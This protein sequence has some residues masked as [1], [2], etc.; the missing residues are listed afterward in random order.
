MN[1]KV[2]S[3]DELYHTTWEN[4]EGTQDVASPVGGVLE[5]VG[6]AHPYF[7]IDETD[8]LASVIARREDVEAV[9]GGWVGEEE[10]RRILEEDGAGVE[11]G[12]FTPAEGGWSG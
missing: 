4:T 5:D 11:E 10:Y 6:E 2:T 9:A 3:A 1:A 12:R 7:G 8:V